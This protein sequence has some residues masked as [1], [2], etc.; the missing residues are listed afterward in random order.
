MRRYGVVNKP[1]PAVREKDQT[2]E[3]FKADR[4]HDK[5]VRGGNSRCMVAQE[6]RPTLTRSSGASDHVFCDSRFG[7]LDAELE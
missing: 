4:G 5:Q 6:S 2:V 7:D 3:Q 1:P